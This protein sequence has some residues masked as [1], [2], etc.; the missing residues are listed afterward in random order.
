MFNKPDKVE[1]KIRIGLFLWV[2][3]MN[4]AAPVLVPQYPAWP[5]WIA[6]IYYFTAGMTLK[7]AKEA[8]CGGLAG[9]IAAYALGAGLMIL[10]PSLGLF[11]VLA[12]GLFIVLGLIIVGGAYVPVVL[13]NAAFAYLTI[14]TINIETIGTNFLSYVLMLIVGGGILVGGCLFI[15]QKVI[16]SETKKAAKKAAAAAK[17]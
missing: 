13:N 5:M 1:L 14:A 4:I 12:I 3:V 16:T 17:G 2:F 7:A 9:L 8:F 6:S 11:R 15:V 10:A